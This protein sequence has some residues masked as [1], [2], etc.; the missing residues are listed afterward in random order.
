[1]MPWNALM[2]TQVSARNMTIGDMERGRIERRLYF[3]LGRFSSRIVSVDMMLQDE[4]GPRGGLDKKCRLIVRLHGANDV[5]VEGRGEDSLSLV[6]RTAN[7]AGRAVSR[8]LD[9]RRNRAVERADRM[10][11]ERLD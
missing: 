11:M 8:A 9:T 4:N 1:M 2:K 10:A 7:R 6:D 5:V 3:T